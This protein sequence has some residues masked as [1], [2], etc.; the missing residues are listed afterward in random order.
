M[1][2]FAVFPTPP[3]LKVSIACHFVDRA[4]LS[5][6]LGI[7]MGDA[8]NFTAYLKFVYIGL[9]KVHSGSLLSICCNP[10]SVV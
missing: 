1:V 9:Q 6:S 5:G 8:V 4:G 2:L 10:E 7:H 3:R